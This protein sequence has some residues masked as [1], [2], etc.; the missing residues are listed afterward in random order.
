MEKGDK[1]LSLALLT[2][3]SLAL[4]ISFY[5]HRGRVNDSEEFI[6]AYQSIE[7]GTPLRI[8]QSKGESLGTPCI[9]P[10]AHRSRNFEHLD[11]I[12]A[13]RAWISH[14]APDYAVFEFRN[15]NCVGKYISN[16]DGATATPTATESTK[17][18][19]LWGLDFAILLALTGMLFLPLAA[20]LRKTLQ[21]RVWKLIGLEVGFLVVLFIFYPYSITFQALIRHFVE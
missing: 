16:S 6:F 13:F 9:L 11:S 3:I 17:S 21:S 14:R 12:L 4:V 7:L 15:G 5:S 19:L 18:L 1:A 8:V 20:I 2:I 10:R